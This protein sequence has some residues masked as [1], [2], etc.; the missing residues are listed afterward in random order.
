MNL[1]RH[2]LRSLTK[3]TVIWTL[4]IIALAGIYFAVYPSVAQD[5]GEFKKLLEGY[6]EKIRA[7]LNLSVDNLSSVLGFYAMMF[8]FVLLCGAI[9]AMN[10][11]ASVLSK[12]AR[13]RTADFL[14]VKPVSRAKIISMKILAAVTMLAVTNAVYYGAAVCM[15]NA[16]T[17]E[18]YSGR[19]FFLIN[20]GLFFTQMIFFFLGLAVSVFFRKLKSV[21]PVTLGIVFGLYILGTLVVTD[22]SDKVRILFPLRY[23]NVNYIIRHTGYEQAYLIA[24]AVIIA[25]SVVASYAVY[26]KKDIHA[27]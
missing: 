14:L 20:A 27:V 23:I 6:P 18:H 22:N 11:G 2:E 9:Q 21:L 4:S 3:S 12:E 26:T 25:A 1:Y 16:A 10:F 24:G 17:T 5:A 8:G 15:A 19:Q 13:E 7:M